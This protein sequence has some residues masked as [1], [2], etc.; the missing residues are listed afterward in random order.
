M[1]MLMTQ[2]K[3]AEAQRNAM[4]LEEVRE[5]RTTAAFEKAAKAEMVA[6][7]LR[8]QEQHAADEVA[9]VELR[10][11]V[12]DCEIRTEKLGEELKEAKEREEEQLEQLEAAKKSVKTHMRQAMQQKQ[13]RAR[14]AK[15][16]MVA[17]DKELG[18]ELGSREERIQRLEE[19]LITSKMAVAQS[20]TDND[21]LQMAHR[22][23][24]AQ[25]R[26]SRGLAVARGLRRRGSKKWGMFGKKRAQ[27]GQ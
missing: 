2:Y 27:Q 15:D 18:D 4:L 6:Q 5:L 8:L 26:P 21:V 13:Q 25:R 11:K 16:T 7:L 24:C 14:E 17:K 22:Q 1:L 23:A 12:D 20:K 10:L 9:V 3:A 19:E